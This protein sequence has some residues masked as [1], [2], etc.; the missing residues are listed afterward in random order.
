MVTKCVCRSPVSPHALFVTIRQYE[1]KSNCKSLPGERRKKGPALYIATTFN[2]DSKIFL[3]K[4]ET[5]SFS[6]PNL[7]F[8]R[9]NSLFT[10]SDCYQI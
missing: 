4:K 9:V 6:F 5:G 10:L 8:L 3:L 7:K 1:R 2:S